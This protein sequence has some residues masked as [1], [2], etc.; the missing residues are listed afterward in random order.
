MQRVCQSMVAFNCQ[1][2]DFINRQAYFLNRIIGKSKIFQ[3]KL[4]KAQKGL[5]F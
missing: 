1:M 2:C 4:K 5:A 3:K